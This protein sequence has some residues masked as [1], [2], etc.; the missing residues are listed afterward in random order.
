MDLPK[1]KPGEIL[2]RSDAKVL[3]G[4]SLAAVKITIINKGNNKQN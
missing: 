2:L 1:V 3:L 4:L